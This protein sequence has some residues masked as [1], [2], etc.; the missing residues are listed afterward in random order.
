MTLQQTFDAA[1]KTVADL[2]TR[3]SAGE[4]VVADA[5]EAAT[6]PYNAVCALM[7]AT[8]RAEENY[9]G[10]D[11]NGQVWTVVKLN[12]ATYKLRGV[13]GREEAAAEAAKLAEYV[14]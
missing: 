12:G 14:N 11:I 7:G 9:R 2:Y 10:E 5:I 1:L 13:F 8:D 4:N 3:L 6:K